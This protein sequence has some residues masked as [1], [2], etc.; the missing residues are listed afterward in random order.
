MRRILGSLALVLL[1]LCSL[2]CATSGTGTANT[3]PPPHEAVK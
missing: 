1:A 2:H 3:A